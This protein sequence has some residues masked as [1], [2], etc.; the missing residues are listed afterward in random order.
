[1][2]KTP[3]RQHSYEDAF[4]LVE[5]SIVLVIIGLLVGGIL[6]GK[7]LVKAAGLR[8]VATEHDQWV[9]AVNMFEDKYF[10]LPGDMYNATEYWGAADTSA[11][12]ECANPSTDVGT[13]TQTCN[14]NNDGEVEEDYEEIRFWQHLSNAG[15][16]SGKYTGVAGPG[17]LDH[18]IIGEN[19]P[20]S[21]LSNAGWGTDHEG[22]PLGKSNEFDGVY[23]QVFMI[24]SQSASGEPDGDI[25]TATDVWNL[26]TKMDDGKPAQGQVILVDWNDCSTATASSDIEADYDLEYKEVDCAVYF[27]N[28]Y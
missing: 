7:A 9:M 5:L 15:L 16:I 14:G 22:S 13:G 17:G 11:A 26:D 1:M 24:G 21:K 28:A 12:G 25:F 3:L 19:V 27:I 18:A 6:G 20:R 4:S 10:A 23:N 2:H 8:A